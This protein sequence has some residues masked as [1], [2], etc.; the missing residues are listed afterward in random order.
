MKNWRT[1]PTT[2]YAKEGLFNIL[3]HHIDF[4]ATKVLDLF[5]GTG[6][7][8]YE[9]I[10]RGS[11]DVICVDKFYG[12]IKF[13]KATAAEL[14]ADNDLTAIKSDVFKFIRQ[15]DVQYDLIFADPPYQLPKINDLP[16]LIFEHQ[17]MKP[18]AW[19]ILEHSVQ[20]TFEHHPNFD[21]SRQY[22]D[23]IF[24]FFTNQ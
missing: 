6:N 10:S 8:A 12:C 16:D 5:C 15:C 3:T 20:N 18:E 24:S 14:K 17:L 21:F 22:G 9:F 19:L 23:S 13:V 1:R 4:E 7:I 2:D 11:T